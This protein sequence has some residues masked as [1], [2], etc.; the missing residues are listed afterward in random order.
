TSAIKFVQHYLDENFRR[1]IQVEVKAGGTPYITRDTITESL[2]PLP[3]TKAEQEAIAEALSDADA[4]I[5]SLEQLIAKKRQIKQGAMQELLTG[6]NRLPGFS[7]NADLVETE[8]GFFPKDWD[9]RK[10]RSLVDPTRGIRYGIVQ[11]GEYDPS[12]RYMIRGQDY[13]EAKG[14]AHPS[15][16]FRVSEPIE[17]RY[18]NARV[19]AGDLIMT[20]VGYCGHIESIPE[21]LDGANLTQTTARIAI[22]EGEAAAAFCK[23]QLQSPVGMGQVA[24]FIKGAAQPGLNCGDVE[25]F[26]LCLPSY[27]EQT[28]IAT[29]L[30]DMDAEIAALETKLAKARQVKQGMMQE[31][32]TGNIRL[33]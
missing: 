8:L 11:P 14:W 5:E 2:I 25:E 13:S 18:R 33:I 23:Y 22:R 20:I 32:L 29:I 17:R 9:M 24:S 7:G 3:P 12:G 27:D 28:A 19:K 10:L 31:L 21:W 15:E 1:R 26:Q 30:S 6:K 4:L 16:V